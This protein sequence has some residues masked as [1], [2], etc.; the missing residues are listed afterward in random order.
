MRF[1]WF[2]CASTQLKRIPNCKINRWNLFFFRL[3]QSAC[4]VCLVQ[5]PQ[6]SSTANSSAPS[7]NWCCLSYMAVRL[8]S[9]IRNANACVAR[10]NA[11]FWLRS[12]G[13][14]YFHQEKK[15]KKNKKKRK[16]AKKHQKANSTVVH[17]ISLMH[18]RPQWE[19]VCA[20]GTAKWNEW[21]ACVTLEN[22]L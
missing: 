21:V 2:I 1:S 17:N 6:N 13:F 22:L 7:T 20:R 3:W 15:E 16:S 8:L 4:P 18:V 5:Q 9:S 11:K 12:N 14:I 10:F 19:S